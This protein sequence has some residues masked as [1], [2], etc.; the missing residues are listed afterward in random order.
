[1]DLSKKSSAVSHHR[2]ASATKVCVA[3]SV[4]VLVA[5]GTTDAVTEEATGAL[6]TECDRSECNSIGDRCI[7]PRRD[8]LLPEAGCFY[9]VTEPVRCWE[10]ATCEVGEFYALQSD[11]LYRLRGCTNT[12]WFQLGLQQEIPAPENPPIETDCAIIEA[13]LTPFCE[14]FTADDCPLNEGCGL[15]LR[16]RGEVNPET[17]CEEVRNREVCEVWL[18]GDS[19]GRIYLPASWNVCPPGIDDPEECREICGS[20]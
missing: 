1:M 3:V 2:R 10:K 14:Q 16:L 6:A 18:P 8:L 13:D 19:R 7:S 12:D 15:G 4:F 17:G 5:C 20:P 11:G 9:T